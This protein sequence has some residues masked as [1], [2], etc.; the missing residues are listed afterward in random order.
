M[1][2]LQILHVTPSLGGAACLFPDLL[3]G[4]FLDGLPVFLGPALL[5]ERR[6]AE[7]ALEELLSSSSIYMSGSCIESPD[8]TSGCLEKRTILM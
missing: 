3:G 6:T 7:D 2:D 5:W 8:S 1:S 4:L